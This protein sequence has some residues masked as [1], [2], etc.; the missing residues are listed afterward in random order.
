MTERIKIENFL[1]L[2]YPI[3]DVRSPME[4][5]KGHIPN[6]INLPLF[7]NEERALVGKAYHHEGRDEAIKIGLE[8]VASKL[9][10]FIENVQV[11]AKDKN[12]RIHCWRGGMRS[13]SMAWLLHTAGYNVHVL[14]GGY[15]SFRQYVQKFYDNP[16][17]LV[18]IGGMTGSGKTE[19]L[20][21]IN[22]SG[23]QII[24]LEAIANHKGSVFGHFG[25]QEQPSTEHFENLLFF[26]LSKLNR[27]LPIWIESE[28]MA[29]GRIY[30]PR[31][32]F[33]QIHE[34]IMIQ[35]I[36]SQEQRAKRLVSEYAC[37]EKSLL[38]DS[39]ERI[40]RRI[41]GDHAN[42]IINLIENNDFYSAIYYILIYYDKLYR[43]DVN[44]RNPEKIISLEIDNLTNDEIINSILT[45]VNK[46]Y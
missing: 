16:F 14:E 27:D 29:I 30:I 35:I 15:K 11:K 39:V 2:P 32:F 45:L 20:K 34:S 28:S 31:T 42:T 10:S 18:V 36:R 23:H 13:E 26:E 37:F 7:S 5:E 41:G 9:T 44:T 46:N 40:S 21:K 43:K 12:I 33:Q 3:F 19:I 8:K 17:K 4:Y 1:S 24:D 38:K 25:Q 6:A 22:D